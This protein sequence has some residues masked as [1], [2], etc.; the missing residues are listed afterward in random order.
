M[1]EFAEQQS[2][3]II[4]VPNRYAFCDIINPVLSLIVNRQS[5]LL[6]QA[7]KIHKTFQ[8]MA[9]N[10]NSIPEILKT[11]SSLLNCSA[12]FVD[13]HFRN[14]YYSDQESSLAKRIM[15]SS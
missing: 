1:L 11:L 10:S 8:E 9:V 13:I 15:E 4:F 7:S 14:C 6:M 12:A 5:A 2:F 3:P